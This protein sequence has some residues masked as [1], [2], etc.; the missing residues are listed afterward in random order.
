[1]GLTFVGCVVVGGVLS[2]VW[3]GEEDRAFAL[4]EWVDKVEW[5]GG[6]MVASLVVDRSLG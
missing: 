1:M 4:Y 2:L 3:E 5:L 6:G